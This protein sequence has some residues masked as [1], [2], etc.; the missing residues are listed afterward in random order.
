MTSPVNVDNFFFSG[1]YHNQSIMST[2]ARREAWYDWNRNM[3]DLIW[4]TAK[5]RCQLG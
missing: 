2:R 3:F 5:V 1:K 4:R